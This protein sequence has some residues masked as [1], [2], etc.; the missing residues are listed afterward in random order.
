MTQQSDTSEVPPTLPALKIEEQDHDP[1][2]P[3]GDDKLDRKEIAKRLTSIVRGQET[4]F[5]ITVDGRWGT[6]KTF[7]LKRWRQ[8]LENQGWQ[9]IYYNAWEDDFAGDPLLSITG[10]LS[11]HF[12]KGSFA[13]AVRELAR[14]GPA[15]VDLAAPLTPYGPIWTLLRGAG[16]KLRR[17]QA[18]PER[19]RRYLERRATTDDFRQR[20]SQAGR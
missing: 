14:L 10:R 16:R 5:V 7:L 18:P 1:K 13:A 6:G 3:W 8:D 20:L 15:L 19:L 4:P 2:N 17:S 12:E 11:E 9:A